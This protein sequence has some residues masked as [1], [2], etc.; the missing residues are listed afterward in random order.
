MKTKPRRISGSGAKWLP[1]AM[2]VAAAGGASQAATVQITFSN[3]YIPSVGISTL[4]T[5]FGGDGDDDVVAWQG[6]IRAEVNF[7]L[8]GRLYA[9]AGFTN[10]SYGNVFARI[11]GPGIGYYIRLPYGNYVSATLPST[12]MPIQFSDSNIRGG[13]V[14]NAWIQVSAVAREYPGLLGGERARVTLERLIFDDTSGARPTDTSAADGAYTEF[15]PVPESGSLA[16]LALGA[17]GLLARRRRQAV[18]R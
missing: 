8:G 9:M 5:D 3:S 16:L 1:G 12:L 18:R 15:T 7:A 6:G 11:S 10:E 13:S 14:T 4:V 17:G 2:A